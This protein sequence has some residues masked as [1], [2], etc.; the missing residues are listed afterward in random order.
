MKGYCAYTS[1]SPLY[2]SVSLFSLFKKQYLRG[3][4]SAVFTWIIATKSK[5]QGICQQN[6]H[7]STTYRKL[8][9]FQKSQSLICTFTSVGSE[10][11]GEIEKKKYFVLC[12]HIFFHDTLVSRT[13]AALDLISIS[14]IQADSKLE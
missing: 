3:G 2:P 13:K 11:D 10:N 5:I 12:D 8:K 14:E 6:Y 4:Q 1:L 7:I 9:C